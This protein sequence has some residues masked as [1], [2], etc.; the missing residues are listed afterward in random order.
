MLDLLPVEIK[1]PKV[2]RSL[3]YFFLVVMTLLLCYSSTHKDAAKEKT[4]IRVAMFFLIL[5]VAGVI[6]GFKM[7]K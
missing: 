6:C 5:G 7:A 2:W 1:D 3:G 4:I